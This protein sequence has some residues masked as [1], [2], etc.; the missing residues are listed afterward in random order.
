LV[1]QLEALM[2]R[3]QFLQAATTPRQKNIVTVTECQ[4]DFQVVEGRV[5][6][7]NLE[8][9][10]DNVPVRSHG[11]VGFDQTL[12]LEIEVPIQDK[13]IER[14]PALRSLAGQSLKIPI[15]GTFQKPRMDERAFA[16][17]SQ[18]LLQGAAT[19]AIGGEL[20][21]QFEKLFRGK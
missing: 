16:T 21:R 9:V 12:A 5:Y 13:W 20:N 15:Y 19:E 7:R 6:H 10:I 3:R 4:I 11:S 17:L 2:K 8:F 18:Q 14:E 1:Q